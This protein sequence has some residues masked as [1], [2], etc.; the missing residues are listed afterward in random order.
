MHY[1]DRQV[2]SGDIP[3][4]PYLMISNGIEQVPALTASGGKIA[5]FYSCGTT[6]SILQT[7][8]WHKVLKVGAIIASLWAESQSRF[9]Y[10]A[11]HSLR[12][13]AS[14]KLNAM[15]LVSNNQVMTVKHIPFDL[16]R[17]HDA[18]DFR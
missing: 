13:S 8:I 18:L 17:L 12:W 15:E 7:L 10:Q 4:L 6:E 16:S 2:V 3:D 5:R 11:Q 14:N 1:R 9:V